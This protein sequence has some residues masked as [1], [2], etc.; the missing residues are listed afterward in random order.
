MLTINTRTPAPRR[1][2]GGLDDPQP[3][4]PRSHR[5][6]LPTPGRERRPSPGPVRPA[7]RPTNTRPA[8][9]SDTASPAKQA[10]AI[11]TPEA[12]APPPQPAVDASTVPPTITTGVDLGLDEGQAVADELA[13]VRAELAALV[14]AG[15]SVTTVRLARMVAAKLAGHGAHCA[16]AINPSRGSLTIDEA[17]ARCLAALDALRP[18]ER[19]AVL[20]LLTADVR[21]ATR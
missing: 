2:G 16:L 19:H 13:F 20:S 9:R 21:E 5:G 7:K 17:R 3:P 4:A 18:V 12:T 6:R 8:K 14:P 1:I 10:A 11:P 15:D